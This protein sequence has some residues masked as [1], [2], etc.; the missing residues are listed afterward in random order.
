[1]S[2]LRRAPLSVAAAVIYMITQLSDEKK[3]LRGLGSRASLLFLS[4][5]SLFPMSADISLATGV[6]EGTI[7]K[8]YKDLHPHA[9]KLIPA[10]FA[11]EED[12]RKLA[13]P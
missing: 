2:P 8:A 4:P 9:A 1:M 12:L 13:T 6:A 11:P 10:S 3:Q 7:K 5:R